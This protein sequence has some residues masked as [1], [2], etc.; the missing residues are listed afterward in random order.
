MILCPASPGDA[1]GREAQGSVEVVLLHLF[2]DA[3]RHWNSLTPRSLASGSQASSRRGGSIG[4]L[5][6]PSGLLCPFLFHSRLDWQQHRLMQVRCSR[7]MGF[8]QS[9]TGTSHSHPSAPH[10]TLIAE[11]STADLHHQADLQ[12]HF[13]FSETHDELL[14]HRIVQQIRARQAERGEYP[15]QRERQ[16]FYK[17]DDAIDYMNETL[18]LSRKAREDANVNLMRL[19]ASTETTQDV[20][21]MLQ[22]AYALT[23][24]SCALS[25]STLPPVQRCDGT[26]HGRVL[27]SGVTVRA[28]HDCVQWQLALV[29]AATGCEDRTHG[30]SRK[31]NLVFL[32]H[33]ATLISK[34]IQG[35]ADSNLAGRTYAQRNGTW[36]GRVLGSG[37]TERALHDCVQLQLALAPAATGCENRPQRDS[38]NGNV[39]FLNHVAKLLSK[40]LQ[41]GAGSN[42]AA[43]RHR[44]CSIENGS[45][46]RLHGAD[47]L[48]TPAA[49]DKNLENA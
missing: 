18:A 4:T 5:G 43:P 11:N 26:W 48:W 14:K 34:R 12:W 6:A 46:S 20:E 10:F 2:V 3:Q 29:P 37:V 24:C 39:L 45:A 33:V 9:G 15:T 44:R 22:R 36:H 31:S 28:F 8:V 42:L 21:Q 38:R 41:G 1:R 32:N 17:L 19:A 7:M 16:L 27:G 40:R 23:G 47:T 30:D 35:E 25:A 13:A 49:K